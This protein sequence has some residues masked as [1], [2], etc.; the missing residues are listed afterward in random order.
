MS[1]NVTLTICVI[2]LVC[3]VCEQELGKAYCSSDSVSDNDNGG[4]RGTSAIKRPA[5]SPMVGQ[6]L[7]DTHSSPQQRSKGSRADVRDQLLDENI[8]VE[9]SHRD[10]STFSHDHTYKNARLDS[11]ASVPSPESLRP[12]NDPIQNGNADNITLRRDEEQQ[13]TRRVLPSSGAPA[14]LASG[15][16]TRAPRASHATRATSPMNKEVMRRLLPHSKTS[17]ERHRQPVSRNI[18]YRN[19]ATG[20]SSSR[21]TPRQPPAVTTYPSK[22][23]DTLTTV[24][25]NF[26]ATCESNEKVMT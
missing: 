19:V 16:A 20:A 6:P 17:P 12:Q 5:T 10:S 3:H 2:K 26:I 14:Q 18:T 25:S 22:G 4:T 15:D 8:T 21:S 7:R 1:Y 9:K 24:L 13:L 23:G 11:R